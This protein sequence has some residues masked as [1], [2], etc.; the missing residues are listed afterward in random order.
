[1]FDNLEVLL[2]EGKVLGRLRPDFVA[3]SQL[4]RQVVHLAQQL[5]AAGQ[6]GEIAI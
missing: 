1:M 2:E 3:C 5:T 4:L 6:P